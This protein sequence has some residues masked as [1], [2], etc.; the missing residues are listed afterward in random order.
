[1]MLSATAGLVAICIFQGD[2]RLPVTLQGWTGFG[3]VAVAHTI[4]TVAFFVA[5]PFLGAVRA[6]MISNLEPVLGILF[7]MAVLGEAVSPL[8]AL[9]IVLVIGSIFAMEVRRRPITQ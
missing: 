5:I 8:Q 9:G 1:M 4:G 7:A 3:G 6:A 2:L